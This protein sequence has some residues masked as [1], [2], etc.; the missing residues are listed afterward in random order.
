MILHTNVDY[1][2]DTIDYFKN[3]NKYLPYIFVSEETMKKNYK[4]KYDYE[5]NIEFLKIIN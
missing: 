5:Y 2:T 4:F 3:E 1:L